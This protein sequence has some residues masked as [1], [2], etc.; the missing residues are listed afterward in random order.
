VIQRVERL[1]FLPQPDLKGSDA[2]LA[3]AA[4]RVPAA[5][6]IIYLP[7]G[8]ARVTRIAVRHRAHNAFGILPVHVTVR[9][10]M[11]PSA[12]IFPMPLFVHRHGIGM[13]AR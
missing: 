12:E 5:E 13:R 10:V 6:F 7:A 3:V 11:T 1:I 2:V 9:A 8:D 4:P